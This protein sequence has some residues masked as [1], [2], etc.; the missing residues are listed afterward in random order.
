MKTLALMFT[1]FGAAL[2][3]AQPAQPPIA[4]NPI[5]TVEGKIQK[6]QIAQGQGMPFI[7]LQS[8]EGTFRV[9]LG[10]VRF[11]MEQDFNPKAGTQISVKGYKMNPDIVAISVTV[12]AEKKTLTLRDDKGWPVWRGG[13]MGH[14][15]MRGEPAKQ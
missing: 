7:E 14:G 15:M 10:P 3:T 9:Y 6:V 5:V 1:L 13:R 12:P 4:S 8:A 11:L 2:S